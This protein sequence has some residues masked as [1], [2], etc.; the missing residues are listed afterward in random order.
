VEDLDKNRREEGME[1]ATLNSLAP[2]RTHALTQEVEPAQ[3][4]A[5]IAS[6]A[7]PPSHPHT[8]PLAV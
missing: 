3:A 5:Y 4:V 8:P 2:P 6:L 7:S 1:G